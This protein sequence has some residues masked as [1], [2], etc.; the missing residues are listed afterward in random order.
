MMLVSLDISKLFTP[1]SIY[2]SRKRSYE[3]MV[4]S[5]EVNIIPK[6][7]KIEHV[8]CNAHGHNEEIDE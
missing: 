4:A 2:D 7:M 5:A 1:V 6:L 8:F 3:S